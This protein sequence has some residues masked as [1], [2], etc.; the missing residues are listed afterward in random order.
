MSSG[1]SSPNKIASKPISSPLASAPKF[2]PPSSRNNSP[3]RRPLHDRSNS[4]TNQFSGPTIRIVEDPGTDIYSKTPFPSQASHVLPA[5][6]RP[7]YAFEGRGPRV[8][9]RS[10]DGSIVANAV[11]KFESSSTLVPKPLQY[12]KAIRHSASTSTSDA[13]TVVASSFS[14]STS[15]RFSQGTTPPSSPTA[16]SYKEKGLEVL[17]EVL[18]QPTRPTIRAVIPSS[19][20]AGDPFEAHALTPKAS[21]A[22]LAST[23][24]TDT[25]TH[26]HSGHK[27][28]SSNLSQSLPAGH[29]HT[30][31]SGSDKK[32]QA[33]STNKAPRRPILK[34]STESFAFSD[35]SSISDRP[36]S[37]S[38]P[39]PTIHDARQVSLASGVR[40]HYPIIRAPSASSLRAESQN[41]PNISSRMNP[42]T[43]QV[44][45]WSSQLSTIH[46]ESDRNS[47]SV[48][49]SSR[50]FDGRSQSVSHDEHGGNGR[51]HL[52]RRRQTISSISSSENISS[53][54]YTEA[55]VAVPL[56]LFSPI[57]GPSG[58]D[59]D[60]TDERHDTISP[61]QSPP[62]RNKRSFLRRHDSDSRSSSSRPGS[63]QSDLSTFIAN[64]IPA[65]A[66]VYYQRG[67]RSS[68]GAPDTSTESSGSVRVGTAQSGRTNTPS[69]GNFPLSI[70]RPR[71]R[72]HARMSH[73]ETMSISD[74]VEHEVYA[75][76][77]PRRFMADPFT[78]HL[79]QDRRSRAQLSAWK[80]PSF[81]ESLGTFM[82][83]RQNRQI[84]LFCLGFIF[85]LAWMIASLLPLPPDPEM[86]PEMAEATPSQM[87]LEQEF[88]RE[89][90]P[91]DDRSYQKAMWWR[92]LNRI[93]SA[94]GTLL[95]GVII[96][97]A[98]LASKMS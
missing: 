15:S 87:D 37:S 65:W 73:P 33:S 55:S 25:L 19:S 66:R 96:A 12:K 18:S 74:I 81:D 97:L 53:D 76:G 10:S 60:S 92:N 17:E 58:D 88:A 5:R 93:M 11:A 16:S 32:K 47:R 35:T 13:D 23:A 69:E 34:P 72:P 27:R 3:I 22:S 52:P 38:Q 89:L 7:G 43:S 98:I 8:S 31:S 28:D 79:R 68:L 59:R 54:N 57:T 4:Q 86:M 41:P 21:A 71:N 30:P 90:G 82:F 78:P 64:T 61:L 85:P 14:P 62:L 45:H 39:S 1:D 24:S 6:N 26:R 44:H 77:P 40:V 56:P 2:S 51:S 42:R 95:I 20:S 84:L 63:S 94:V 50:S 83:S 9:G 49:R 70:Y 75:I 48:E 67:E 36:R 29:K 80:A 46:S 91:V